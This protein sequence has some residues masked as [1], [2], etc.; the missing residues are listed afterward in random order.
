MFDEKILCLGSNDYD[1]DQRTQAIANENNTVNHGLISNADFLPLLPGY[2]HTTVIDLSTGEIISLSKNFDQIVFLDQSQ[3]QWSHWKPMLTTYKIMLELDKL[4]YRTVFKDNQ[5]IKKFKLFFEMVQENKSFCIYPWIE[6]TE[7]GG[8]LTL[9]SRSTKKITS[10]TQ[11]TNWKTDPEYTKIRLSMLS[12]EL[13]PEH[14]SYCYDY[15]KLGIESYRQ[16]ET[17]DWIGKLDIN[18]V[19]DLHNID[20]PYYYEIRLNNKC[21]LMCRGCKPEYSHLIEK[22]YKKFNIEYRAN[23]TFKYSKL[24][25]INIDTLTPNTRVYLTGGEPTIISEVFDFMKQCIKKGKTD[26]DFAILTNGVKLSP[27]FLKLCQHFSNIS[28]SV[29]VDGYGKVNDYYR[30]G[31][32]FDSVVKNMHLLEDLGHS[33]SVNCVPGIYTVTNLH[34]LYEFLDREFPHIGL[35]LQTNAHDLQS[36][37]NHP[38]SELVV[39]SMTRCKQ[40]KIYYSDGKSNQTCIDSLYTHYSNNP[41]PNLQHLKAFFDYNDQLDRARNVRLGDYVPE[42]EACRKLIDQ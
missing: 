35:Y 16:F 19:D 42:L 30:W 26:F 11:L 5:N 4:G 25:L 9:C 15:E 1:T 10:I 27:Q 40:T 34:L 36:A 7:N 33:I 21:N 20:R 29:S 32:D 13:L 14:C 38:N 8:N 23:Q 31:S 39:E 28:F 17:K 41:T 6:L 37:Y 18:S 24:N 3:A 22:E 12:G 2:Y